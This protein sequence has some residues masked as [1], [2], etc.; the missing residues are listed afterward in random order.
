[1]KSEYVRG[2]P[3]LSD[4]KKH[5]NINHGQSDNKI[6]KNLSRIAVSEGRKE[7]YIAVLGIRDGSKPPVNQYCE[8]KYDLNYW[9]RSTHNHRT[10]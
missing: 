4:I 10:V 7:A 1:M 9:T 6:G 3:H 8:N 5:P 2:Q